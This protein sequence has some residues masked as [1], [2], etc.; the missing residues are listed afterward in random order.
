MTQ[1]NPGTTPDPNLPPPPVV[2]STTS[3]RDTAA[4][5][6][7][8]A[9]AAAASKDGDTESLPQWARDAISKANSEAANYRT[10]LREA[11]QTLA[12][13]KTPEDIAAATAALKAS[14]VELERKLLVTTVAA[15]HKL[16]PVLAASLR[17]DTEAELEAHA[18]ELAKFVPSEEREVDPND[19]SGGLTPG[20]SSTESFDPV[21]TARAARG[22]RFG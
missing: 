2:T 14:N 6:A 20:G 3:D 8:A 22:R 9:A 1:P 7:A 18:T 10:K 16:P 15:K 11:E 17:G 19:L 21:A 4:A 5:Q 13:A 12:N